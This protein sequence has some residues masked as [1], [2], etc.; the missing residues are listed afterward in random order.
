MWLLSDS[1]LKFVNDARFSNPGDSRDKY[2]LAVSLPGVMPALLQECELCVAPNQGRQHRCMGSLELIRLLA[3]ARQTA[4]CRLPGNQSD[5]S[6]YAGLLYFGFLVGS[7]LSGPTA[8]DRLETRL[9]GT[10]A[11]HHP[12][13]FRLSDTLKLLYAKLLQFKETAKKFSCALDNNHGIRLGERL[14][15]G[16]QVRHFTYYAALLRNP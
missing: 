7:K 6:L 11:S 15:P 9:D 12:N 10:C 14:Q 1:H 5:L 13:W 2:R 16:R 4:G 3:R 8:S